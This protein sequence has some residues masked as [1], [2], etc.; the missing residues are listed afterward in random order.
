MF[1]TTEVVAEAIAQGLS[2]FGDVEVLEADVAVRHALPKELR[3]LV[4][5][6]PAY[7]FGMSRPL[8]RR[9]RAHAARTVSVG[10]GIREW[11]RGRGPGL[12]GIAAATFDTRPIYSR[13]TASARA[14]AQA[15][16]ANGVD[17][18]AA[19]ETFLTTGVTG[20]LVDG[21]PARARAWGDWLATDVPAFAVLDSRCALDSLLAG[22]NS[23]SGTHTAGRQPLA[24]V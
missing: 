24:R 14:A 6:G 4:V 18:V 5:G 8:T 12:S 9:Q 16:R 22:Q 1:G 7:T 13:S 23:D 15:L 11:I 21:E 20:R 10:I 17:I 19:P 2:P 3:L